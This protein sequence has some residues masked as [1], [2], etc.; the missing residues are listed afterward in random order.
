MSA[1]RERMI[2]ELKLRG[3]SPNTQKFLGHARLETTAI[4]T[5]TTDKTVDRL[6]RAL[7]ELLDEL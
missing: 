6:H 4:Y 7:D 5:H 2:E 1:L 3:R